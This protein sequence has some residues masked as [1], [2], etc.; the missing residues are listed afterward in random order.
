MSSSLNEFYRLVPRLLEGINYRLEANSVSF[1]YED[2]NISIRTG[3]QREKK[4]ASLVL[5]LIEVTIEFSALDE[6]SI[7]Q[8]LHHFGKIY[9][10]GG[11]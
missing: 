5:P 11:G 10:R 3:V 7:E 6:T 9:Q 2:G 1:D 8:F 4:I